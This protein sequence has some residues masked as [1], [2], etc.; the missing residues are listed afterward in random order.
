MTHRK[1]LSLSVALSIA[2]CAG[3]PVV[4]PTPEEK[5]AVQAQKI[6]R[7]D[8]AASPFLIKLLDEERLKTLVLQDFQET[9]LRDV[10]SLTTPEGYRLKYRLLEIGVP[11]AQ[12]FSLSRDVQVQARLME[13]ARWVG[14]SRSRAEGLL[15]LAAKK[16]PD[17][18]KVFREAL[19]DK[20]PAL[21]FAALEALAQWDVPGAVP[22]LMSVADR[23]WSSLIRVYAAQAACRR[24]APE[25]RQKLLT[26]LT[27]PDWFARAPAARYLGDL[28]EA[29]DA[30]RLISRLGQEH[31]N[32]FVVA[33]LCIA[34]LKLLGKRSPAAPRRPPPP[35]SRPPAPRAPAVDDLFELEP[36]VVTAPRLK[37]S[38]EQ[39]IDARIDNEL[40]NLLEKIATEPPPEE[41]IVDPA[42]AEVNQ[43]VTPAGFGLK[44]RYSDIA[45]LITEGLAGTTNL[46]L[47]NRLETIARQSPNTRARASALVALGHDA[48]RNDLQIFQDALKDSSRIVRFGAV[49]ALAFQTNP[50]ARPI[51]AGAA[52]TDESAPV[53]LFAAQALSRA[54]DAQGTEILRRALSDPDWVV[55]AL[56]TYLVG[57]LG[58]DTDFERIM[59]NM[60]RESNDRVTA[61]NCLAILRLARAS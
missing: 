58:D 29:T 11:V 49:E 57:L 55:R 46:T 22:F 39:F 35:A 2:G 34:G 6:A 31:G 23:G 47:I 53:R 40:V 18:F 26:F 61:E 50:M 36:L 54:G 15:V 59:I 60:N 13:A 16:N 44:I 52:Q 37:I 10:V 14:G 48:T 7:A 33:E 32:S 20:N 24:G 51:L 28:G 12:A 3:A 45:F 17:H 1:I 4:P 56:S 9:S 19:L 8:A 5:A 38:G 41:V 43:L 42:L 25:G 27:D 21:Q 30:D